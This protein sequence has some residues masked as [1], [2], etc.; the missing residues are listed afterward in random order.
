MI[1]PA[2]SPTMHRRGHGAS[3][4]APT[5][6]SRN[7]RA[8]RADDR[9]ATFWLHRS[10]ANVAVGAHAD[11]MSRARHRDDDPPLANPRR[12]ECGGWQL[13]CSP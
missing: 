10:A 7:P 9:G 8:G 11:S 5:L 13:H 1:M 3:R 2:L 12:G 6:S 4:R